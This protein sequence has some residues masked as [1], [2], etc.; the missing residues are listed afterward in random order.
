MNYSLQKSE[1]MIVMQHFKEQYSKMPKGKL[2]PFESP[3][4]LLKRSA[5][6]WIGIELTSIG[7]PGQVEQSFVKQ[8]CEI[9]DKKQQKAKSYNHKQ[10]QELWLIVIADFISK[11]EENSLTSIMLTNNDYDYTKIFFF[12]LFTNN[13]FSLLEK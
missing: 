8:I 1:E 12:D 7:N 10:V 5:K 9:I 6:K 3:D 2:V 11:M 13:I 4:F